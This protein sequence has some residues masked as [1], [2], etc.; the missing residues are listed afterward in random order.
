MEATRRLQEIQQGDFAF[1]SGGILLATIIDGGMS[2][3]QVRSEL[4]TFLRQVDRLALERGASIESRSVP[5]RCS[6]RSTLTK[7]WRH[8]LS[9]QRN[10]WCGLCPSATPWW[11]D[12]VIVRLVHFPNQLIYRKGMLLA[13]L[14]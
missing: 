9:S 13:P 3:D 7:W 5:L 14:L 8:W 1:Q 10:S 2:Q 6:Q 12:P 4:L 11:S